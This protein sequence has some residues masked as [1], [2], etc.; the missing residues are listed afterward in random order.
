MYNIL[1]V[2]HGMV[3]LGLVGIILVQ[4]SSSDMG[5]SGSSSTSFMSGRA[6][7]TFVTRTT[8]ALATAF[9]LLSLTLGIL[10]VRNHP[11]PVSIMDTDDKKDALSPKTNAPIPTTPAKPAVPRP[12]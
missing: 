7:A 9:I 1:L 12:E 3:T 6:A 2:I 5:L 8:A 4:R 10:T 11:T